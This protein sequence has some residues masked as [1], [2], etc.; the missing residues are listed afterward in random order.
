MSAPQLPV[1]VA[2]WAGRPGAVQVLENARK[3][4]E[5]GKTGDRAALGGDLSAAHRKDVGRVLGLRWEISGKP[6]TLGALRSCLVRAETTLVDVLVA[7]GGPLRDLP[8]ER[9]A[10]KDAATAASDAVA[11]VLV[12]AGVP[13]AVADL[14]MS[15]SRRWLG[16]APGAAAT[17]ER[18]A[19]LLGALPHDSIMLAVLASQLYGDPHALDHKTVLGRA[20]SRVL[21]AVRAMDPSGE[22]NEAGR[23]L[24]VDVAAL[25]AAAEEAMSPAG[26]HATW[27]GVGV[28]CDSLSSTVLALNVP[29]PGAS[30]AATMLRAGSTTGEPVWLTA[31]SLAALEA[32]APESLDEVVIRVCENPSVVEAAADLHGTDCAP[33]VC[34]YGRPSIAAWVLLSALSGAGA[35]LLVSA[36]RDKSGLD[37]AKD[38]LSLP[39]A[40][41]WLP[42]ATGCYE[43]DRLTVLLNDLRHNGPP[44]TDQLGSQPK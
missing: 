30:S 42:E 12:R 21:G 39:G 37:I 19:A 10:A 13:A 6:A 14:A 32:P 43:E 23:E 26:R 2:A 15:S 7:T 35:R 9:A 28:T 18:L 3:L 1:G 31:R 25:A 27:A 22:G 38:L 44:D 41:A 5:S 36:D 40:C 11:A 20:A 33:L 8:G 4:L 34:T 16:P 24:P 17:A 29:L